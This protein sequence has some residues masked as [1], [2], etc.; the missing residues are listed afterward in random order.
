MLWLAGTAG[1]A[2]LG[3]RSRLHAKNSLSRLLSPHE[4]Q[5]GHITA[6]LAGNRVLSLLQLDRSKHVSGNALRPAYLF[7]H[8]QGLQRGH[9][10]EKPQSGRRV[11]M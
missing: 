1:N 2:C 7:G 8:A 6:V 11:R 10:R 3:Q 9:A 4:Q 5:L